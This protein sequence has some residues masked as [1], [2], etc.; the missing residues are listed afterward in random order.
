MNEQTWRGYVEKYQGAFVV[1]VDQ[2]TDPLLKDNN[3]GGVCFAMSL[4]FVTAYQAGQP[5]PFEFVNG[6]R[7]TA[8]VPPNTNRV[9][10]KYLDIQTALQAML[11]EFRL[12]LELL[13]LEY[14]VSEKDQKPEVVK[15]IKQFMDDR[16]KQRYGPGMATYEKFKEDSLFAA[17]E[18]F[19]RMKATVTKNGNSYFLVEMRREK[20]SG[21]HAIAF[22]FRED[23]SASDKFPAIYEYF[24]ANLGY[25]VFPSV[26]K[27]LDFFSLK[28]WLE[29]YSKKSY[30]SFAIASYTAK[31]GKR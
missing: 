2:S 26:D 25:F 24:D 20:G 6:I 12:N 16:I 28:V 13:Q 31:N 15:N 29:V 10:K 9:P 23:L 19:D 14:E 27:L 4:D 8:N 30:S 21:G 17:G 22:G 11:D 3:S 7:D 1:W 18:L 5:G